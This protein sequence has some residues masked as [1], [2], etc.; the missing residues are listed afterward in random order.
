MKIRESKLRR[1]IRQVLVESAGDVMGDAQR[2]F[3]NL[4]SHPVI[5]Q[6]L[7]TGHM[8]MMINNT[9]VFELVRDEAEKVCG[10]QGADHCLAVQEQVKNLL[11][12]A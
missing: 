11:R 6:L 1:I 2:V 8:A 12:Q 9:M 4:S 3:M 7:G 5:S 10:D